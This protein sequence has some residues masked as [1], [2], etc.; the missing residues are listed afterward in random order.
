MFLATLSMSKKDI[1][2]E[3]NSGR[4]PP[5]IL[6]QIIYTSPEERRVKPAMMKVDVYGA[7]VPLSFICRVKE[8]LSK[9]SFIQCVS[10]Y[11]SYICG[12]S[13]L[14]SVPS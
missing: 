1:E 13:L 3:I 11:V 12:M 6:Y 2:G 9:C 14:L 5:C 10:G 4:F 8:E 7:D